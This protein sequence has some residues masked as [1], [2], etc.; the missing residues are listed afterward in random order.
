MKIAIIGGNGFLGRNILENNLLKKYQ[1]ISTYS[2]IKPN[3]VKKSIIWKKLDIFNQKNNIY[4]YLNYPDIIIL[5]SWPK[6]PNYTSDFH[7]KKILPAQ[8]KL[9]LNLVQHGANN[10]TVIGTC[11][12]YGNIEGKLKESLLTKPLNSYSKAKDKLRKFLEM[13]SKKYEFNY[14][15]ARL[16][17]VYG[18]NFK[19]DTLFNLILKSETRKE[20]LYINKLYKRDYLSISEASNYIL[21][22]AIKKKN[23]GIVNICSGKSIYLRKLIRIAKI[24]NKMIRFHDKII[25]HYE[26]IDFWGDNTKLRKILKK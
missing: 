24:N 21:K 18:F 19:R 23:Y 9:I 13:L 1:V 2:K 7:E 25:N 17:Y 22:L 11:F 12:E 20:Y 6:L 16:F 10:I 5:C 3:N 26:P 8:K 4:E 15:W 14:T